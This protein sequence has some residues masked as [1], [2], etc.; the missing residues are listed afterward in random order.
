MYLGKDISPSI[1]ESSSF[2]SFI[3]SISKG[4]VINIYWISSISLYK[5]FILIHANLKPRI[6][7]ISNKGDLLLP[8]VRSYKSVF[9]PNFCRATFVSCS[10]SSSTFLPVLSVMPFKNPDD[11]TGHVGHYQTVASKIWW[12]E[13]PRVWSLYCSN[14]ACFHVL[15]IAVLS[16]QLIALR[17]SS[18]KDK[19]YSKSQVRNTRWE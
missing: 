12:I 15:S 5:L 10:P 3:T 7:A 16:I 4:L 19:R 11:Q 6:F 2:D 8:S 18:D 17:L 1:N 14:V 9:I 13:R